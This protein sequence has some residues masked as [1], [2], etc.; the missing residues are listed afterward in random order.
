MAD[1]PPLALAALFPLPGSA[2][3]RLVSNYVARETDREVTR[4]R[5]RMVPGATELAAK[6]GLPL[7]HCTAAVLAHGPERAGQ[8]AS[9]ARRYGWSLAELS[10][11]LS[12]LR[13]VLVASTRCASEL[14]RQRKGSE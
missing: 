7:E 8:L 13:V 1:R 14:V 6:T 5:A 2:L 3:A 10:D 4:L 12:S 9:D 11:L